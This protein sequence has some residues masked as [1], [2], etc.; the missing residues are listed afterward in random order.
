VFQKFPDSKEIWNESVE[1]ELHAGEALFIPAFVWQRIVSHEPGRSLLTKSIFLTSITGVSVCYYG[2][3]HDS[4]VF[5]QQA[6]LLSKRLVEPELMWLA[7]R[8]P[9]QNVAHL[10]NVI[11][12]LFV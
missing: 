9:P 3:M 11:E 7:E 8:L 4:N 6:H 2:S 10:L 1:I 5:Q 12:Y